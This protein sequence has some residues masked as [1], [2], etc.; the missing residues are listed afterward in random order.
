MNGILMLVRNTKCN[1]KLLTRA[2]CGQQVKHYELV[3]VDFELDIHL[4]CVIL[5]K[6]VTYTGAK[7]YAYGP[8]VQC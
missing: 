5:K 1:K 3:D 4:L 7:W 2:L 6:A 8:K